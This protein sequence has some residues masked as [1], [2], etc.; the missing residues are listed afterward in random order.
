MSPDSFARRFRASV[1]CSY[2]AHR[3]RVLV[4][5][6]CELWTAKAAWEDIAHQRALAVIDNSIAHSPAAV[7][8][9]H[10]RGRVNARSE[11]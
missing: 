10:A 1:G 5:R 2:L 9:A 7:G 3:E 11:K 8:R 4:E 6:A